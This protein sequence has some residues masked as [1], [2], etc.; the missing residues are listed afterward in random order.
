MNI[1]NFLRCEE[2][3]ADIQASIEGGNETCLYVELVDSFGDGWG[4][5]TSLVYWKSIDGIA[6]DMYEANLSCKCPRMVGCLPIDDSGVS[7]ESFYFTVA[8]AHVSEYF[9][10]IQWTVQCVQ[11]GE[12]GPKYY[13]GYNTSLEI[14][15]HQDTRNYILDSYEN[16]WTYPEVCSTDSSSYFDNLYHMDGSGRPFSYA[17]EST[18]YIGSGLY[19]TPFESR[20]E[21]SWL[22]SGSCIDGGFA[23]LEDGRYIMRSTGVCGSGEES[24][25]WEACNISGSMYEQL[26]FDF[27]NGTCVSYN[28]ST[29]AEECGEEM[30]TETLSPSI[31]PSPVVSSSPSVS[32]SEPPTTSPSTLPTLSPSLSPTTAPT[33]CPTSYR[34]YAIRTR[35]TPR[36]RPNTST[37][38]RTMGSAS[39]RR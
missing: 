31:S 30:P 15:Y 14:S 24:V 36:S 9:W 38:R 22:R 26:V 12:L 25:V 20:N 34:P 29:L 11:G 37:K 28:L 17:N 23:C 32:A 13:G 16:M 33:L 2:C 6:S 3:N 19:I 39:S 8:G 35:T 21:I 27:V 18:A 10:E 1:E 4:E 5:D 7:D